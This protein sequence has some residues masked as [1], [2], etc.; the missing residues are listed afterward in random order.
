M[1]DWEMQKMIPAQIAAVSLISKPPDPES[2]GTIG[3]Y[4]PERECPRADWKKYKF[5][6]KYN[7]KQE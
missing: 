6:Y 5:W 4:F 3:Y 7:W 2:S 1:A